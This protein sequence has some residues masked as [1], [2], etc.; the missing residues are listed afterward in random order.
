MVLV[1]LLT[2]PAPLHVEHLL[3]ADPFWAPEPLHE[4]HATALFTLIFFSTPLVIS[5]KVSFTLIRRLLPRFTWRLPPP[6]PP[7]KL[8]N[9]LWPPKISPNWL[10]MSS[11]FIP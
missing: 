6:P 7:K 3:K 1:T 2:C 11:I 4:L 9:G 10:K 8:S 5:A